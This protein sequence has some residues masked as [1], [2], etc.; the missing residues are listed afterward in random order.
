MAHNGNIPAG[1]L[2]GERALITGAS[3]GI[4]AEF[5]R[6]FAD[7]GCSL[8][9]T[10]RRKDRLD[11][12]AGELRDKAGIDVDI[13][14]NNAGF[15]LQEDFIERDWA[16]WEGV[17]DLDIKAFTHIT[18]V[19]ARDMIARNKKG[20]ILQ[21]GSIFSFG[22]VPSY[23]VYSAAKS[24]VLSFSEALADELAPH[25]ITVTTL[26]PGVTQ[27]EFFD[28]ASDGKVSEAGRRIMQMPAEVVADGIKAMM[29]GRPLVV[30][31]WINR[32]MIFS[33][34]LRSR[35]SAV[36]ALG[37]ASRS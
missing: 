27:T 25:G 2:Q 37:Q 35:Q 12:L 30:S 13:I 19:F 6:Q 8:V 21:I 14:V 20:R 33:R 28:T 24:Y 17:I 34:R 18:H 4:G 26:A 11:A 9:L 36:H 15:G 23:A 5:A 16:D 31:G 3:S 10:A 22:G 32:A 1:A 29:A 7:L